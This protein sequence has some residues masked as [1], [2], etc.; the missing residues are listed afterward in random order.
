MEKYRYYNIKNVGE[1][2]TI[3]GWVSK[4]RNLGG[5]IFIDLRNRTGIIQVVV[6]PENQFYDIACQ[7][8]NEYVIKVTGKIVERESKN[9]NLKTGD[10]E[11]EVDILELINKSKEIPFAITDDTTAL[12]DTRLKYRYLDLRRENLQN[13]FIIRNKITHATRNYFSS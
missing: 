1:I 13:K 5:L 3:S 11:V 2:V 6:K 8:R 12:E 7:L 4:V 10:I 9:A